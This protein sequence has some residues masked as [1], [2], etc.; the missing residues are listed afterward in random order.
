MRYVIIEGPADVFEV[1]IKKLLLRGW[2]PQGGICAQQ[3][4]GK[5]KND[6]IGE[7]RPRV[8]SWYSQ[9]MVNLN[10][11]AEFPEDFTSFVSLV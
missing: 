7:D 8:G 1:G 5:I 6:L 4:K 10:D 3:I 2:I 11:N 9:A